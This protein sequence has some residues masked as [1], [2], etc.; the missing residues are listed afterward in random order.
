MGEAE[1]FSHHDEFGEGSSLHFVHHA[2]SV[3]LDCDFGYP[4]FCCYLFVEHS[5]NHK[6]HYLFFSVCQFMISLLESSHLCMFFATNRIAGE[7]LFYGIQQVLIPER[8]CEKFQSSGLYGFDRHGNISMSSDKYDGNRPS[9]VP[10]LFL[11]IETVDA[12]QTYVENETIGTV[13]CFFLPE[14]FRRFKSNRVQTGRLK[15]SLDRRTDTSI[16]VNYVYCRDSCGCHLRLLGNLFTTVPEGAANL[17]RY[18]PELFL[19][20][21]SHANYTEFRP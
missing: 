8:L 13:I 16:V 9:C 5:G 18:H 6:F 19:G 21:L 7:G 20:M 17:P 12:R 4:Q 10:K 2:S 14:L 3:D 1:P 11:E 15:Q